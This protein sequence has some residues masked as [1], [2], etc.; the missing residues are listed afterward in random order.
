MKSRG[1]SQEVLNK[2]MFLPQSSREIKPLRPLNHHVALSLL[3]HHP[4][5]GAQQGSITKR[6]PFFQHNSFIVLCFIHPE[7]L[8]HYSGRRMIL[9][10]PTASK[11]HVLPFIYL[12]KNNTGQVFAN[13]KLASYPGKMYAHYLAIPDAT[14]E[15]SIWELWDA[16]SMTGKDLDGFCER[17]ESCKI[18]SYDLATSCESMIKWR[19]LQCGGGWVLVGGDLHL[20]DKKV[21]TQFAFYSSW[22][23]QTQNRAV[24]NAVSLPHRAKSYNGEPL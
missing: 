13:H 15:F 7:S 19:Y 10:R 11:V 4:R 23:W 3:T 12:F 9:G 6:T 20:S 17:I 22:Q 5:I 8:V 14:N 16:R 24:M 21:H 1:V 2:N 18:L